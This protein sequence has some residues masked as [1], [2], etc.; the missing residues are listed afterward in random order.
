MIIC[1]PKICLGSDW[2]ILLL[3]NSRIF[4]ILGRLCRSYHFYIKNDVCTH[5]VEVFEFSPLKSFCIGDVVIST[6]RM[7]SSLPMKHKCSKKSHW[8]T[9]LWSQTFGQFFWWFDLIDLAFSWKNFDLEFDFD[10]SY[11]KIGS[12]EK[13]DHDWLISFGKK[14]SLY[15]R[16]WIMEIW[17][18]RA[19]SI[20][21]NSVMICWYLWSL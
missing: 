5:E 8:F 19:N 18:W 15:E 1:H 17:K 14:Q 6:K 16:N 7:I 21:Q 11:W 2:L 20:E 13:L 4:V 10:T 12:D 3:E 9:S